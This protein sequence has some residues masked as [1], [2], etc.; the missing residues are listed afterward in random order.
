MEQLHVVPLDFGQLYIWRDA[1]TLTLIDSGGPGSGPAIADAVRGLGLEL[2][3]IRRIVVTHGHEDHTGSAADVRSWHGAQVCAHEADA[4]VIRGERARLEPVLTDFDAPLWAQITALGVPTLDPPPCT[5]DVELLDGDELDFGGGAQ[6]LAL[7]G[8]TP[9]SIGIYLPKHKVLFAGDTIAALP[10]G[11]VVLGVFNL[12]GD[13]TL[14]GFR[15]LA[16]LDT[17]VACFGHGE[18]ALAGA[19]DVLRRA[20]ASHQPRKP[21]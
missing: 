7:P 11:E 6:I 4:A 1:D 9:G 18:P 14:D 16:E 17:E 13:A 8:H 15:R 21:A 20:V 2:S 10:T 19:G 3:A 12:D 5:V